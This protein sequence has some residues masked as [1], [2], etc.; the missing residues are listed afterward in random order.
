MRLLYSIFSVMAYW[1]H[2]GKLN[3]IRM[4]NDEGSGLWLIFMP[5]MIL[6]PWM[7]LICIMLQPIQSCKL[8]VVEEYYYKLAKEKIIALWSINNG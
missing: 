1:K 6:Q 4:Q 8:T 3:Y 7:H 5:K 2:W